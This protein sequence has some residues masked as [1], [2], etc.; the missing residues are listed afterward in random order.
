L[1]E[2][3]QVDDLVASLLDFLYSKCLEILGNERDGVLGPVVGLRV[4]SHELDVRKEHSTI[5]VLVPLRLV[6][7]VLQ[8]NR[9][10][11][12]VLV[13]R[14]VLLRHL[15]VVKLVLVRFPQC[16]K[17]F[18]EDLVEGL[19]ALLLTLTMTLVLNVLLVIEIIPAV[20]K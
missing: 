10:L 13:V 6:L 3:L 15:V 7:H 12:Q 16:R 2:C 18:C 9:P 11:D 8:R 4:L 20:A 19:I 17:H 14:R 1:D 5:L